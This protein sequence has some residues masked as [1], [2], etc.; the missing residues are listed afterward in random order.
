VLHFEALAWRE[1]GPPKN[2]ILFVD[3]F[4]LLSYLGGLLN[5]MVIKAIAAS[6]F[7]RDVIKNP[8]AGERR[9]SLLWN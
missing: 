5:R 3:V 1:S 9:M 2:A 6:L 4:R 7:I 8:V